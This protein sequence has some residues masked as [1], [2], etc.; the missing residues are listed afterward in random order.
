[1]PTKGYKVTS[2]DWTHADPER[3]WDVIVPVDLASVFTGLKPLIP[4]VTGTRDQTGAWDAAGQT[5]KIDLADGTGTAE[6]I[7]V[8][9]RPNV[10]SYT[11]GPFTGPL[12][13]FVDHAD[14]EFKFTEM[15]GGTHVRW[16][17]VWF[18]SKGGTPIVWV[19]SK[20]WGV[21]ARRMVV[22]LAKLAEPG[23]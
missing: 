21:Y 11:V 16:T 12:G 7:D 2:E 15:N 8:A 13:R 20:L 4:A 6:R 1:M 14:G 3:A 5:R 22:A 23:Q 18:P 19:L 17:Y 9:D 10:F